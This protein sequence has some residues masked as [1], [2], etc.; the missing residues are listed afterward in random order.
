MEKIRYPDI[1][2]RGKNAEKKITRVF[3]AEFE[4]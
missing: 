1:P 3:P 4:P 2:N